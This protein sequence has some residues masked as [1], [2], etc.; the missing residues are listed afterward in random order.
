MEHNS[1]CGSE[2]GHHCYC[3]EILHTSTEPGVRDTAKST[4]TFSNLGKMKPAKFLVGSNT[5]CTLG[6]SYGG[7]R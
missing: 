6:H 3:R 1:G 2:L 5:N 4:Q 7:T